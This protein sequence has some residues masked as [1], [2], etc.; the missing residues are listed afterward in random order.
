[1]QNGLLGMSL[2]PKSQHRPH[3]LITARSA[4]KGPRFLCVSP[5]APPRGVPDFF[6]YLGE[7][8]GAGGAPEICQFN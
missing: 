2:D 5:R 6:V 3:P 8:L 1:M 7:P 4:Q